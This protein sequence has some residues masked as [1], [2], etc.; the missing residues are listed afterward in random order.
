M[1]NILF[2]IE[3]YINFHLLRRS[4]F[5]Y[6]SRFCFILNFCSFCFVE[7]LFSPYIKCKS[8]TQTK[9]AVFSGCELIFKNPCVADFEIDAYI[10]NSITNRFSKKST[11]SIHV[12]FSTRKINHNPFH[13]TCAR[14]R[15]YITPCTSSFFR[16][17]RSKECF[18]TDVFYIT[19]GIFRYQYSFTQPWL[20]YGIRAQ[21]VYSTSVFSTRFCNLNDFIVYVLR[22]GILL[23]STQFI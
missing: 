5:V 1:I 10:C 19:L 14:R 16:G 17:L 15:V 20:S 3:I 2:L 13:Y 8:Q 4:H 6:I 11:E 22:K 12:L 9:F 23:P 7:T 18:V 21:K